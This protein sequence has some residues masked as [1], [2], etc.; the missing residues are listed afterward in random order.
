MKK[1]LTITAIILLLLSVGGN[2]YQFIDNNNKTTLLTQRMAENDSLNQ[3][4]L[5]LSQQLDSLQMRL[6]AIEDE[7]QQLSIYSEEL[8]RERDELQQTISRL[9]GQLASASPEKVRALKQELESLKAKTDTFEKDMAALKSE[10]AAL[11]EQIAELKASNDNLT[12]TNKDLTQ[13]VNIAAEPIFGAITAISGYDKK[14]KFVES[15]KA[16]KIKKLS[17]EIS[18]TQNPLTNKPVTKEVKVKI[19]G[20]EGEILSKTKDNPNL[21]D[22]ANIFSATRMITF[23]GKAM[24][25]KFS[26]T[27]EAGYKKGNYKVQLWCD[28]VLKTSSEFTLE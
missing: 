21:T 24:S 11:L 13:K 7:R 20:P 14:G 22:K 23:D 3:E 12:G 26:Y 2:V 17:I 10:N 16:K 15:S 5:W 4:K 6:T 18:V 25:D 28:G 1:G 8:E 27:Q 9:R 19:I